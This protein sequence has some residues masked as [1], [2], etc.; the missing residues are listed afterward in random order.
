MTIEEMEF[1]DEI[2]CRDLF[3]GNNK[4]ERIMIFKINFFVDY[5]KI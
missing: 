4:R 5:K 3:E 1:M 2:D